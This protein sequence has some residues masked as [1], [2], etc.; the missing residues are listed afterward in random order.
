MRLYVGNHDEHSAAARTGALESML[1][2]Y[3]PATVALLAQ[4][5]VFFDNSA[6]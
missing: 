1:L 6:I 5:G 3:A 4:N 2:A